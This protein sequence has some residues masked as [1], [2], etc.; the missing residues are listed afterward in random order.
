MKIMLVLAAFLSCS[1]PAFAQADEPPTEAAALLAETE[2]FG[3]WLMRFN[4][5]QSP[6][7]AELQRMGPEWSAASQ[8]WDERHRAPLRAY[9]AR[10]SGLV[11]Q[12]NASLAAL[13]RPEFPGLGLTGELRTAALV[14]TMMRMNRDMQAVVEGMI[15]LH[16][17]GERRDGQ[18]ARRVSDQLVAGL[19]GVIQSQILLG[20]ASQAVAPPEHPSWHSVNFQLIFLRSS[21]RL[22][23]MA[24]SLQGASGDPAIS[25]D[26]TA[27]ASELEANARMGNQ[28]ADMML[29]L[30]TDLLSNA[31]GDPRRALRQQMSLITATRAH[32]PLSLEFATLLR[33]LAA[34]VRNGRF[35]PNDVV[36]LMGQYP[37]F[38]QRMDAITNAENAV[39][40]GAY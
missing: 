20:R 39:I 4:A 26:L 9:V 32:F 15:P 17:A 3:A 25:A 31:E 28:K 14:E 37:G 5:I 12:A 13:D 11:G 6:L 18:A 23:G 27:M 21:D 10:V 22:I 33:Q 30:M 8:S 29:A 2:A 19:R 35:N 1:V 36:A 34:S 40:A 16:V 38:R 24:A 7:L